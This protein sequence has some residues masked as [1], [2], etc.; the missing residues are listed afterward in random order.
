MQGRR[1]YEQ[2]EGET[3]GMGAAMKTWRRTEAEDDGE[4]KVESESEDE[5]DGYAHDEAD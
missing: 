2:K 1:A 4:S 3:T 5:D